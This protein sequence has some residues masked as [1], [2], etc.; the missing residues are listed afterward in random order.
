M[1]ATGIIGTMIG[2]TSVVV[3]GLKT[4][5]HVPDGSY[6]IKYRMGKPIIDKKTGQPKIIEPGWVWLM[7]FVTRLKHKHVVRNP[8][9]TQTVEAMLKNGHCYVVA[10]NL[11][12]AINRDWV[13][14]AISRSGDYHLEIIAEIESQLLIYLAQL[15]QIE[16]PDVIAAGVRAQLEDRLMLIG[17]E[18]VEFRLIQCAPTPV[19]QAALATRVRA[20]VLEDLRGRLPDTLLA[21]AAGGAIAISSPLSANGN[22]HN[23]HHN[24]AMPAAPDAEI[25]S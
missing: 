1:S 12:Y 24:G 4:H 22:N 9:N 11:V 18:V 7:P 10:A 21:A 2:A 15:D 23:G 25:A 20:E 5:D 6:G 13:Y 19:T 14:H 3:T 16:P 8:T 17:A